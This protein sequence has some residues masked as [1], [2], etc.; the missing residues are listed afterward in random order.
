MHRCMWFS[1]SCSFMRF[2]DIADLSFMSLSSYAS[3]SHDISTCGHMRTPH[4]SHHWHLFFPTKSCSLGPFHGQMRLQDQGLQKGVFIMKHVTVPDVIFVGLFWDMPH[5][6]CNLDACVQ[7]GLDS[8]ILAVGHFPGKLDMIDHCIL[9]VTS[10]ATS[11]PTQKN[12]SKGRSGCRAI[13]NSTKSTEIIRC[14]M[15]HFA[16]H[17]PRYMI[18]I[19][20]SQSECSAKIG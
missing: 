20:K 12:P 3:E 19:L 7:F 17:L 2:G 9:T 13:R 14:E 16:Y 8:K 5:V 10:Q 4:L 18:L 1:R 11:Q 15:W 6:R